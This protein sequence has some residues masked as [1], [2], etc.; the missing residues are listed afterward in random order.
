M[1][2]PSRDAEHE[3]TSVPSSSELI[4]SPGGTL[5]SQL[6]SIFRAGP[7]E[8][9]QR[10]FSMA[11][12]F[13]LYLHDTQADLYID[14]IRDPV[15]RRAIYDPLLHTIQ[16]N[17]SSLVPPPG[18]DVDF[19][20]LGPGFPDKSLPLVELV[21]TTARSIRYIPVDISRRFLDITA[22]F[23]RD[24]HLAV[25]PLHL[26]FEE[27]PSRLQDAA[28]Y[29]PNRFR[30]FNLGLTFDNYPPSEILYLL[31]ALLNSDSQAIIASALIGPDPE[32]V[33]APYKSAKAR[34]FNFL[35]LE[36]AGLREEDFSYEVFL[37]DSAIHMGFRAKA[38]V[39]IGQGTCI[40]AGDAIITS[41]SF[42][43][44]LQELK[45]LLTPAFACTFF[46][47]TSMQVCVA[48]LQKGAQ[49]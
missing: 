31:G 1:D 2:G 22:S 30:L 47:S 27:L 45:N 14:T 3:P 35:V 19:I 11:A 43:Y 21:A 36:Y 23:F 8:P 42:R 48:R 37:V 17:A 34:Q 26:L 13:N 40:R 38:N 24:R 9:S 4:R 44:A 5:R 41:I 18:L 16:T 46:P 12:P 7:A 29:P 49:A 32:T 10:I 6:R 33:L 25:H 15:F 20:D 39:D 28:E